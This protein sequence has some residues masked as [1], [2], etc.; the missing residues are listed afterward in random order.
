MNRVIKVNNDLELRFWETRWTPD[1]FALTEKNRHYLQP[2]LPWVPKV[3]EVNDSKK[4]ILKCRREYKKG[5]AMELGIWYK[6]K[7]V[8]CIGLHQI[9][10]ASRNTAIGYWLSSDYYGRGIVTESVKALV[11]YAFKELKLH[12]IEIVAGTTNIKSCAIAERL[13]FITEGVKR[14]IEFV[15]NRFI[16]YSVY[17]ILENEWKG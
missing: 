17:S 13:G 1:L 14:D 2:W 4:F 6:G 15:D 9:N 10:K 8:G 3:K 5:E 11:N 7:L 16:D 12:R